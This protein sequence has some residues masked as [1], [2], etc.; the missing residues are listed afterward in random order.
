MAIRKE[1]EEDRKRRKEQT[2]DFATIIM[3]ASLASQIVHLPKEPS[4][5]TPIAHCLTL[6][7][8]HHG[9][10]YSISLSSHLLHLSNFLSFILMFDLLCR[11]VVRVPGYR[12]RGPGFDSRIYQI[13]WKVM[14][15]E[16]G[17]LSLVSITEELL[18]RN[19]SGFGLENR[20]YGRGDP[21]RWPRDTFNPQKLALTSLGRY[22]SLAD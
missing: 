12:S 16:W 13:F 19:S 8:P 6:N 3:N 10:S 4:Q 1:T 5:C 7:W 18:G 15:L 11:L 21:L 22:S 17:P 20:E 9:I 14:G 2:S